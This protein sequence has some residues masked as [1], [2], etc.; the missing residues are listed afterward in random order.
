[1]KNKGGKSPH[2]SSPARP[3]GPWSLQPGTDRATPP[4]NHKQPVGEDLEITRSGRLLVGVPGGDVGAAVEGR[5]LEE[6]LAPAVKRLKLS[7]AP[8]RAPRDA[9]GGAIHEAALRGGA[10]A[11]ER[12]VGQAEREVGGVTG[13]AVGS[14]GGI[15]AEVGEGVQRAEVGRGER[16][17][18]A[19]EGHPQRRAVACG[20][21]AI[22]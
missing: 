16:G 14:V 8:A 6:A 19:V 21:G 5:V 2:S 10:V 12:D 3:Q 15:D 7:G 4:C 18:G 13:V 17:A 22:G 11:G 1:M 9:L 20:G